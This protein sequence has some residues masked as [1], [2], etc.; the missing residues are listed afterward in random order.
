[1]SVTA[2]ERDEELLRR[3]RNIEPAWSLASFLRDRIIAERRHQDE[4]WWGRSSDELILAALE[5]SSDQLP[6]PRDYP[7]DPSD[8]LSCEATYR[9]LP[10]AYQPTVAHI[11]VAFR[12]H[13]WRRYP[14]ECEVIAA[15]L[16]PS[17]TSSPMP[18]DSE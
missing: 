4:R 3:I 11:M 5:G 15:A 13:V 16:A 12:A 1:M 7:C 8:L 2:A 17:P 9:H 18:G 14:K 6:S 10:K